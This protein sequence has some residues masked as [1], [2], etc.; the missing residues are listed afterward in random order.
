MAAGEDPRLTRLTALCLALPEAGREVN[1]R[2]AAFRVRT[3]IF[4]Y[5][6]DHHHGDGIVAVNVKAPEGLPAALAEA[7]GWGWCDPVMSGAPPLV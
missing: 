5:V 2:H 7:G 6:L 1:D 4:A 3:R